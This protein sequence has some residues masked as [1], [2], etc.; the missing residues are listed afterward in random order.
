V[1]DRRRGLWRTRAPLPR[2]RPAHDQDPVTN[3]LSLGWSSGAVEGDVNRTK[4]LKRQ[5]YGRV[6]PG[7]LRCGVLPA[8]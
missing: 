2:H 5:M 4:T 7:L 3:G 6:G 8:D 1:N